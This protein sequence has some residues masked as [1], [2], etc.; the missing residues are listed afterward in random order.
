MNLLALIHGSNAR[1]GVFGEAVAGRGHRLE[2]WS[3]AWGTPP[4][5]PIDDYAG[6]IVFGGSMHAD[7]DEHHPWLREETLLL[8]RL[9]DQH[10]PVLGVCLGS[11]LLARAA[12]APVFA[13]DEPEIGWHT[14]ELDPRAADD[15]LL[16]C[17]PERF[18]AFQ[19]HYYTYRV[20]AAGVELARSESC[21][22]A[23][24]LG[25]DAWGIQFHP[26][27]TLE[28]VEAW[29]DDPEDRAP[30]PEALRAETREKIAA[31]NELGRRLCDAFVDVA[32]R[33]AA[34]ARLS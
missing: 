12:Q 23:F 34:P 15:P 7:Q 33:A 30:D 17:L 25:S 8:Q 3:M 18:E 2:E 4:V 16:S 6:V 20:P 5:R 19:W 26:E 14:V 22:Q 21:T 24:R 27:V 28:Q 1:A 9:L 11:Q 13:I 31:W 29:L 10:V 32:E